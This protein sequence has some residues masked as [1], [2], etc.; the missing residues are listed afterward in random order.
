MLRRDY[1]NFLTASLGEYHEEMIRGAQ[2]RAFSTIK[3]CR[4][5]IFLNSAKAECRGFYVRILSYTMTAI[6]HYGDIAIRFDNLHGFFNVKH[7]PSV[8]PAAGKFLEVVRNLPV[9]AIML[10]NL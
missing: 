8:K 2:A 4:N 5:F 10:T 3:E 1:L 7:S 6:Q 9:D